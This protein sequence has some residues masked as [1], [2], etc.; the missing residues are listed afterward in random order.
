MHLSPKEH[1][2]IQ[3]ID[4]LL[5]CVMSV[6]LPELEGIVQRAHECRVDQ[7]GDPP[8]KFS[9]TRQALRMFWMFRRN[10]E[11]VDIHSGD[12]PAA[13]SEQERIDDFNI[14]P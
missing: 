4:F 3:H 12:G 7:T 6:D 1:Q 8:E 9:V 5:E 13:V 10:L 2:L 14:S 11:T